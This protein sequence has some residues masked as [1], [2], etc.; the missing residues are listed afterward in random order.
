MKYYFPGTVLIFISHTE[1][2][3]SEYC[4]R[5]SFLT[6]SATLLALPIGLHLAGCRDSSTPEPVKQKFSDQKFELIDLALQHEFGAVVQYG[7][8]AGVIAHLQKNS[9]TDTLTN[10]I[11]QIINDEVLHAVQLTQIMKEEGEEPTIAVWPP[12][13][14]ETT[15]EMIAQDIAAESGAVKLYQQIL[16][17]NF[18]DR[19]KRKIEKIM[20]TEKLHHHIFSKLP[21]GNK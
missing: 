13:T 21:V 16:S 17:F 8:H 18:N 2:N 1:A 20:Q 9:E 10:T 6:T 5:R 7:N 12:Q 11:Q 19:V 3:M 4:S 14:A 15:R